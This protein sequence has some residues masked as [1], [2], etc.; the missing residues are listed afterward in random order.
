MMDYDKSS[1]SK[2]SYKALEEAGFEGSF[3]VDSATQVTTSFM[4]YVDF[5][6]TNIV[7]YQEK[8]DDARWGNSRIYE[9]PYAVQISMELFEHVI[10]WMSEERKTM[11]LCT[12]STWY[13][14]SDANYTFEQFDD[15]IQVPELVDGGESTEFVSPL[16]EE[17][18]EKVDDLINTLLKGI[19]GDITT[20]N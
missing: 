2:T 12:S 4:P 1:K 9:Y 15:D 10:K 3:R 18:Q 14:K 17:V 7:K 6:P 16:T 11:M 20:S 19:A 5:F 8:Y 13:E